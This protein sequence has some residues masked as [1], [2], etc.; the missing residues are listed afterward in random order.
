MEST[1]TNNELMLEVGGY[2]NIVVLQDIKVVDG[3]IIDTLQKLPRGTEDGDC[4][5]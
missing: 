5:R 3:D 2:E 4:I 1:E